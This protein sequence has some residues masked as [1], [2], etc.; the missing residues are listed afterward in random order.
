MDKTLASYTYQANTGLMLS[1]TYGN[2][3]TVAYSYDNLG[4]ATTVKYNGTTAY[5]YE[6]DGSGNLVLFKDYI[7][8]VDYVYDYDSTGNVLAEEQY[9]FSGAF[10]EGQYYKYNSIIRSMITRLI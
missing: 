7:N 9:S 4:R 2:G 1:T 6:Y 8:S 10:K 3:F 5:T